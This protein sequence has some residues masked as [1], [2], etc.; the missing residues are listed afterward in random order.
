MWDL[1][2]PGIEPVSPELAGG[3]LTTRPPGEAVSSLT[4]VKVS[5]G[6]VT[7]WAAPSI[8]VFLLFMF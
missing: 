3:L 8:N 6:G 1:L 7:P 5:A 4:L 2:G